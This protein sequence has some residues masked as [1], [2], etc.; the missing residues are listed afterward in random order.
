MPPPRFSPHLQNPQRVADFLDLSRGA[1]AWDPTLMLVM[2]G[3]LAL[4]APVFAIW[5]RRHPAGRPPAGSGPRAPP[6]LAASYA[7]PPPA[8]RPD[9]KLASGAALFGAGWGLAGL[10]PGPALL[11]L[12]AAASGP[13]SAGVGAALPALALFNGAMAA[14]WTAQHR[15][16]H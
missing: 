6:L 10:C 16:F 15:I 13:A 2:G 3:A 8:A 4:C 5:S 1:A 9:F 14:G 12:G 7:L 11:A